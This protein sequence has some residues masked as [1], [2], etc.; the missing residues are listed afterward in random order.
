MSGR[1]PDSLQKSQPVSKGVNDSVNR[2]TD[3][4]VHLTDPNPLLDGRSS[5]IQ[6]HEAMIQYWNEI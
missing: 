4:F 2:L 6:P 1:A 3:L 5:L